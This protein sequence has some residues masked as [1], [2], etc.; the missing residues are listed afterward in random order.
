MTAAADLQIGDQLILEEDYDESYIPSEQEI[1]EYAREIGIDPNREPE[2]LWL[3]REGIVAP[4]PPE[5]KPCQDVTGDVYYF[6]FS[7]GQSTWDHPCDEQY[8]SLVK[9]ERERAG[10]QPHG[11]PTTAA[12][13]EKKKKKDKKEKKKKEKDQELL[14]PPGVS[15]R[16]YVLKYTMY[17]KSQGSSAPT[18][19][20]LSPL[21]VSFAVFSNTALPS[22]A[23]LSHLSTL[24]P[25][26]WA[27]S[28]LS[29]LGGSVRCSKA[30]ADAQEILG[31]SPGF[32]RAFPD[33]ETQPPP[34]PSHP[35]NTPGNSERFPGRGFKQTWGLAPYNEEWDRAVGFGLGPNDETQSRADAVSH[36]SLEG[37][38]E[39]FVTEEVVEWRGAAEEGRESSSDFSDKVVCLEVE[40]RNGY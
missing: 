9:Q 7:S 18:Q 8:R 32:S 40:G 6:N 15:G 20:P 4:L 16:C 36:G 33:P 22:L 12:K 2:L 14:K 10:T 3:A 21:N 38:V 34:A 39:G 30:L 11:P 28:P 5:W 27:V 37:G 26:N 24:P 13:K 23:P 17:M 29:P 1:H 25:L 19:P 35:P 31:L